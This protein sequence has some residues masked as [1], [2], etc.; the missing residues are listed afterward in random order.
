MA[1]EMT[2]KRGMYIGFQVLTHIGLHIF[3][4]GLVG[5]R[6]GAA[7]TKTQTQQI[8]VFYFSLSFSRPADNFENK[9]LDG[10]LIRACGK[11][12]TT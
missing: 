6:Y 2:P 8:Y 7:S 9:L 10:E 11:Y 12:I 5:G 3:L 4:I 1:G